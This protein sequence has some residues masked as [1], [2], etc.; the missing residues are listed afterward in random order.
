[1]SI[2]FELPTDDHA[3]SSRTGCTRAHW[4]GGGGRA[5]HGSDHVRPHEG[6]SADGD[7]PPYGRLA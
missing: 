2:P 6:E 7:D 3:V 1:M 5:A 4:E